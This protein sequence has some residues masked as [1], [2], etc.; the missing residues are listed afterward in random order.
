MSPNS[1]SVSIAAILGVPESSLGVSPADRPVDILN[2][3]WDLML[4]E[5]REEEY[6]TWI[7]CATEAYR[8]YYTGE[9]PCMTDV[10]EAAARG[11]P[12]PRLKIMCSMADDV[13]RSLF[14][15]VKPI[16]G[17]SYVDDSPQT[18][19]DPIR[20]GQMQNAVWALESDEGYR[21]WPQGD[22]SN[23][24]FLID[25]FHLHYTEW[26]SGHCSEPAPGIRS[27]LGDVMSSDDSYLVQRLKSKP[28]SQYRKR[29]LAKRA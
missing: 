15:W 23:F 27:K 4:E 25:M 22:G 20:L 17:L 6:A 16:A 11:V 12:E 14:D 3:V 29:A 19:R 24:D 8:A 28:G 7:A 10:I 18:M 2:C 5:D 13:P 9:Q 1:A 26:L 21:Y